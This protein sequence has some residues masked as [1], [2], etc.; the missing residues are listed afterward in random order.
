MRDARYDTPLALARLLARQA[1]AHLD[2]DPLRLRVCD[3][4]MGSGRL[5]E[6]AAEV[7][8]GR[9]QGDPEAARRRVEARCLTGVDIDRAA[10]EAARTAL[11]GAKLVCA[12]ALFLDPPQLECGVYH[13]VVGNPP[14]GPVEH[15]P[16]GV[17]LCRRL[18]TRYAELQQG[19]LNLFRPF[20]ALAS[21]L[22]RPDG[23][24]AMLVPSG[25]AAD[26]STAGF[27][28]GLAQ[29]GR[30]A[31]LFDF[32]NRRGFFPE[33]HP[34]FKFSLIVFGGTERRFEAAACAAWVRD[35]HDLTPFPLTAADFELVNPNTGTAP[36]FRTRRDAEVTLAAYRRLPVLVDRRHDPPRSAWP[37]RYCR[38]LDMTLDAGRFLRERTATTVP[39]YEGK[40]VQAYDHRAASVATDPKRPKRATRPVATTLAE[41]RDPDFAPRP[42]FHVERDGLAR[43]PVLEWV[44][45]FKEIAAATNSRTMIAAIAP[46]AAFGNKVPL[47]LPDGDLATYHRLAPL[48][49]AML[50]SMAFDYLVRQKLHG[51]TLNLFV[52][53]Q[54]AVVPPEAFDGPLG[55]EVRH[56][57]LRLTYTSKDLAP[58]ARDQGYDGPPFAW[59]EIDRQ[60]RRDRLDAL[61]FGLFGFTD[62]E[63]DH[64]RASFPLVARSAPGSSSSA[65]PAARRARRT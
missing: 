37:V 36:L 2:G 35:L 57:V 14:W 55:D 23:I 40:M 34:A 50:N 60:G 7:L 54:L 48:L 21:R 65:A 29:S 25:I 15:T 20:V 30:L 3:P 63:V 49:V 27:F 24:V 31:A 52:L 39:L 11:P 26:K 44:L 22:V 33:V 19:H 17:A 10:V 41:H 6:A 47:L 1:L 18:R 16:G 45:C 42:L 56:H 51:Q 59:D 5:L 53:E 61:L 46:Y 9:L 62:A 28:R 58:F 38:M 8:A 64:I 32:E 13:A 4:A 12:D 43:I